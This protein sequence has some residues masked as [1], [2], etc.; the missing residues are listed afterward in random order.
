MADP[1]PA[2]PVPKHPGDRL[3]TYFENFFRIITAVATLGA[4]I[5]FAKIVQTPVTPFHP[6]GFSTQ[7]IQYLI[8]TSWLF[9]VLALGF[10][11]FFASALSLWRPQ[12]VTAFGTQ[13]GSERRKVLWYATA[14]SA[15]LFGLAIVAFIF[16]SLVVVAYTGPVGWVA[17]VF[18]IVAALLGFGSI[19]WQSP[20]E[21]PTW[22]VTFERE[23]HDALERHLEMHRPDTQRTRD[24]VDGEDLSTL[25]R[26][27]SRP[28]TEKDER[29]FDYRAQSARK[30][31]AYDYGRSTSGD[32][33]GVGANWRPIRRD[34]AYDVNRYSRASTVIS[35]AY[36]PGRFGN[37]GMIYD[38]GVRE[39]LVMSR[40]AS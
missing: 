36:D 18:T 11:S 39:G 5:T 40:Y 4:S 33:A 22:L 32:H 15:M 24:D 14:V 27:R 1:P 23:E 30:E 38:D 21:W 17:V 3:A 37:G 34:D 6:Y 10:T 31:S 20:L 8:S 25:P 29:P 7:A 2:E 9:F 12:A 13:D 35:D 26:R 28:Q 19:V 16:V